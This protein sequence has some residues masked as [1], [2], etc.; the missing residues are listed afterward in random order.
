MNS[1][2]A[3]TESNRPAEGFH[4]LPDPHRANKRRSHF[5]KQQPECDAF[6][7]LVKTILLH[8]HNFDWTLQGFGFLRTYLPYGPNPKRFRLNVWHNDF[9]LPGVSTIHDH[10]WDFTSWIINGEFR[11]V[12]FVEDHFNGDEYEHMRIKCG[13]TG[14]SLGT[15]ASPIRLRTMPIEYYHT[16]DIYNQRADEIHQSGFDDGTVTL[17]DRTGDTEMPRVF[18]PAG[19]GWVDAKPREATEAEI[20]KAAGLAVEKWRDPDAT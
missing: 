19:G 15:V 3:R 8:P 17:N 6:R 14:G 9:T 12:R 2:S 4:G 20:A 5:W 16:G 10:P 11:N 1:L 7:T 13:I 18:W